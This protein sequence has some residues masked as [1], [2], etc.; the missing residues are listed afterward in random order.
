MIKLADSTT[1]SI[2]KAEKA[3]AAM[4]CS[5]A[6]ETVGLCKRYGPVMAVQDVSLT[7]NE[8]EIFGFLGPNGAGKTTTIGMALGLVHPTAGS[9][10][11]FGELIS[12]THTTPLRQVGALVGSPGMVPMLTGR[13]NLALL[14][15]LSPGVDRKQVQETLQLV[16]LAEAASRKY[17][18]YSTGMK[19][20]LGLAAALL[21]RPAL[22]ILDEPTNGLDPAGM[23]EIR[24]LLRG[25]A[26]QGVTVFL[27]SHLLHEVEQIC[28]RVAVL[29][30][31]RIIVQGTVSDLLATS[32]VRVRVPDPAQAARVLQV[33]P[34]VAGVQPDGAYV[35][36]EGV[37][38]GIVAQHLVT[39][40]IVP[41]ELVPCRLDLEQVF[42]ELTRS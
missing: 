16:G 30:H 22:L 21:H 31:G 9:V 12:P 35:R 23:H 33:L 38:T 13:R 1:G 2:S 3:E 25:L 18:H 10:R 4:T 19:Q 41:S 26:R 15:G 42:L 7:V 29:H 36:V 27:S 20:R 17:Q 8:G 24:A 28:D 32:A 14:A 37:A 39:H 11:I 5:I 34:G 6:L 40:G